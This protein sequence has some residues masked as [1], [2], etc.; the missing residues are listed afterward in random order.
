[1]NTA[2]SLA[3]ALVVLTSPVAAQKAKDGTV[4]DGK[5]GAELDAAVLK[6]APDFWGAVLVARKDEV[7]LAKGYGLADYESTPNTPRT[8]FELASAS[9]QVAATAILHLEQKRKLKVTDT[10]G[11]FFKDVPEDKREIQLH[12]LLTHTSGISGNVGVP[13]ASP[14][15]R[16]QY[17]R[18]MLAEPLS[19]PPG[20]RF[21]YCNV[22]YALL[23]AVVEEVSGKSFEDYVH[24]NL[25]KP[26]K[27]KDT[28]FITDRHLIK[29]KRASVR[30]SE[31][32]GEWTA[33]SWHWGWGYRG[34]GGVVTTVYDLLAWDRALRGDKLLGKKAKEKLYTPVEDGYA[35][36]WKVH[37]T[38]W[39]SRKAHHSGG[40]AGYGTNVVRYLDDDAC[41][42]VLS[43]D[44]KA[45]HQVSYELEQVL[46]GKR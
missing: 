3:L 35:Y 28:G 5:A 33:A 37:E 20:E 16:Q 6:A 2:G 12:H 21:E 1:M 42:F 22:G 8:L 32:P 39:G 46:F 9:K 29:T 43:N 31:Q 4:V 30:K 17:V 34:M 15:G 45:A 11:E 23:A 38:R 26:A 13:Y 18:D 24:K 19:S 7:L 41:V 27:L 25:F 40:V 14:I 44:G 10:L 36:G